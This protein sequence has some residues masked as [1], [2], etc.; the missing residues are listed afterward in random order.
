MCIYIYICT[1]SNRLI[2]GVGYDAYYSCRRE[3]RVVV[4][5]LLHAYLLDSQTDP[6]SSTRQREHIYVAFQPPPRYVRWPRDE[7]VSSHTNE[8]VRYK[9]A[10]GTATAVLAFA[11]RSGKEWG[12]FTSK[13]R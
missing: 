4:G 5:Y 9:N 12:D 11:F 2:G 10:K 6:Y 8:R 13:T 7:S 3:E 1:Y